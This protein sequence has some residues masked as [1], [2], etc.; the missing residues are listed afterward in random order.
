MLTIQ[1]TMRSNGGCAEANLEQLG[2]TRSGSGA[3][4]FSQINEILHSSPLQ[5]LLTQILTMF[6][7]FRDSV[8]SRSRLFQF[9]KKKKERKSHRIDTFL[10]ACSHERSCPSACIRI[11]E[12]IIDVHFFSVKRSMFT[13]APKCQPMYRY[14]RILLSSMLMNIGHKLNGV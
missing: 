4:H 12:I 14:A 2:R 3:L 11:E 9:G 1:I 8:S 6:Q 10:L 7:N 5:R 13:I